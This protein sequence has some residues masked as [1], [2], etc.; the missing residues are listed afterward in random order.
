M[1][2]PTL[3]VDARA[4]DHPTAGG[5]G[6]GNWTAGLLRGLAEIGM[7]V[8]ALVDP[9]V[10][11]PSV[12]AEGSVEV[13][14][15]SPQAVRQHAGAHYVATG[16][17]LPPVP[18][19]PIP[20]AVTEAG[21]P[22]VGVMYDVIPF[23]MPDVYFVDD[24]A[25]RQARLRA[26]LAR[27]ID[28][29][30]AISRFAA[31][32]AVDV[33]GLDPRR[34]RVVGAGV[35]AAFVP[36]RHPSRPSP[37][38][39]VAVTGAD[40]RKNTDGLLEA[41]ARL[42]P[43][44]RADHALHVVAGVPP[45]Q[46]AAW[47]AM[48]EDLGCAGSVRFRGALR[49]DE[50]VELLQQSTLAVQPSLDE[51]FGLPVLEAAACGVPS[52][53]S[54]VSSL[55]EILDEPTATFDPRDP[56]GVAAAIERSLT[57][58]AHRS[59]LLAAGARAVARWRWE[60]VA[61][62]LVEAIADVA[63][64][65]GPRRPVPARLALI[66]PPEVR[67]LAQAMRRDAGEAVIA[68]VDAGATAERVAGDGG[69]VWPAAAFGRHVRAHD[70]DD[71]VAVIDGRSHEVAGRA[72]AAVPSHVWIRQRGG[73]AATT[74]STARTIILDR[75][76]LAADLDGVADRPPVL[77]LTDG[78]RASPDA[79]ARRLHSWIR[80]HRNPRPS[81]GATPFTATV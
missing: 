22:V 37:K 6:I 31:E 33:I 36:A 10:E 19:D 65:P 13:R 4:V 26:Q 59:R 48:A 47:R 7:P 2:D 45:E 54:D 42:A 34:V 71:L 1:A 17:F 61:R 57:D 18:F 52:I 79:T 81:V 60:L 44:T 5:R 14:Q 74:L 73:A 24:D 25:I 56:A 23:R 63:P 77:V 62:R 67:Q 39:V 32:T 20:R 66:G 58:D 3:L 30:V 72:A 68:L 16:L 70:I 49:D 8:T 50:V 11:R 76:E 29:T 40:P 64:A 41:W 53:C 35:G 69:L 12:I 43:R 9:L 15:W 28:L 46:E 27:T 38:I 51:G 55:P 80:A 78:D 21:L 75:P